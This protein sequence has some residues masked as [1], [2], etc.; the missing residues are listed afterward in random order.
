MKPLA[1]VLLAAAISFTLA[2]CGGSSSDGSSAGY[3]APTGTW[4]TAAPPGMSASLTLAKSSGHFVF[5]CGMSADMNQAVQPD[6]A[7]H[8]S[9]TGTAT[10]TPVGSLTLPISTN[11]A[12][13]SGTVANHVMTV[14]LLITPATGAPYTEGPYVLT[15]GQSDSIDTNTCPP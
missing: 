1:S 7:G 11:P 13:F 6:S 9:V 3:T 4:G 12:I 15:F 8:F 5:Y 10:Y 14:T 2:G